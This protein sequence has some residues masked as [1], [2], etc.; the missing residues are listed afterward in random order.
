[1]ETMLRPQATG[2]GGSVDTEPTGWARGQSFSLGHA[3]FTLMSLQLL[4]LNSLVGF[5]GVVPALL[6][7]LQLGPELLP[8][9]SGGWEWAG[10][11]VHHLGMD[12]ESSRN[13]DAI[14]C[15]GLSHASIS[16][17]QCTLMVTLLVVLAFCSSPEIRCE[18]QED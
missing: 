10:W 8:T 18:A 1:M 2:Q 17:S 5:P 7:Q 12:D 6:A 9:S 4:P 15:A 13:K 3:P 14:L 11:R 16:F